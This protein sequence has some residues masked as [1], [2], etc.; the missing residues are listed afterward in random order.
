MCHKHSQTF[1]MLVLLKFTGLNLALNFFNVIGLVVYNC[2]P[3]SCLSNTFTL[4]IT[5]QMPHAVYKG[6]RPTKRPSAFNQTSIKRRASFIADTGQ[7]M[8]HQHEVISHAV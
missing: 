4:T 7:A 6:R 8:T 1:T 5:H 3:Y 2:V